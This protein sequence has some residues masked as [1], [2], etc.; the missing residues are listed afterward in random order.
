MLKSM[1]KY[2][3]INK[4]I[5][6]FTKC[7]FLV[8]NG[9]EDDRSSLPFGSN[10]LENV[11]HL[12][13]LGS[14]LSHNASLVDE[15]VLHMKK[16]YPGVIKYYNFLR[17]NKS[18]PVKVKRKVLKS[19][20]MTS[21][22]HNC[23]AFGFEIPKDLESTYMKLMKS[24]FNVRANTPNFILYIESGLLPI[25]FL[26]Y[27]RQYNFYQRFRSSIERNS[28]RERMMDA[29][30][31]DLTKYLKHYEWLS[32][33]YTSGVDIL[34]EG[35]NFVKDKI[36]SFAA[37]RRSKYIS[38]LKI[39]PNLDP[40]PFLHIIHPIAIDIIRFRVGS[41]YLPIETGRWARKQRNERLC[42]TCG[43]VGDEE[44]AI[45][46]CSLISRHD[47]VSVQE[48]DQLWHQ[49]EVYKLFTRMKL[50]KLL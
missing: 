36:R 33:Q 38:Y 7:E 28:R 25:K 42:T 50:A 31:G 43:V 35:L 47:I 37:N 14:H 1:L 22:L 39:N 41:H 3:D 16:R 9:T 23:E 10:Y 30:L 40:S 20:V 46:D 8:V 12:L 26:I 48:I 44:H 2:C 17:S 11:D 24:C 5:P 45:Y 32:S 21:L 4:I 13:L 29:L 18:A 27:L 6:Q 34:Q 15:G 19:C 49:P